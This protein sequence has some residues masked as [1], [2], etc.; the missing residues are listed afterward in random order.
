LLRAIVASRM[1]KKKS[2]FG[3]FFAYF[4]FSQELKCCH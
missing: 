2:C 4:Y 3:A 1:P